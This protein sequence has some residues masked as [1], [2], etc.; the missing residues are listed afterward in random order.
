MITKGNIIMQ[1]YNTI[2]NAIQMRLNRCQTR[3]VMEHYKIGSGTLNLIVN[4]YNN[5]FIVTRQTL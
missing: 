3:F 1:D 2:I 5:P 4:R